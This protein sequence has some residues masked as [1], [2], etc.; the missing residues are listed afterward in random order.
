LADEQLSFLIADLRTFTAT[1]TR[2]LALDVQANLQ[3]DT[4]RDVGW[5]RANWVMSVGAAVEDPVV[6]AVSN[7]TPAQVSQAQVRQT[8]SLGEVTAYTDIGQGAIFTTNNVPYI[9][10]LNDGWSQ[11]A[12]SAFIQRSAS[13]AMQEREAVSR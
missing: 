12:G 8:Q 5:A 6:A 3:E 11:Q 9:G 2:A 4:P 7:P 10:R 1:E 13:R